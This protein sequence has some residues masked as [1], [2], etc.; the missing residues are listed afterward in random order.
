MLVTGVLFGEPSCFHHRVTNS[1][2]SLIFSLPHF[3]NADLAWHDFSNNSGG[4]VEI[5]R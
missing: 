5:L 2:S 1:P 4:L 3:L